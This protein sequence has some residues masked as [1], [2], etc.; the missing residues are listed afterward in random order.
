[1][2]F[3][4]M[5]QWVSNAEGCSK[6]YST[7]N[8]KVLAL[9][10]SLNKMDVCYSIVMIWINYKATDNCLPFYFPTHFCIGHLIF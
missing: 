10:Y 1:M 9:L 8:T 6:A 3:I 7:N 4:F 2:A 5:H